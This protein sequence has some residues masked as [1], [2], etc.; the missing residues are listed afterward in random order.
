MVAMAE[1]ALQ[2]EGV[3][4]AAVQGIADACRAARPVTAAALVM[5]AR[6][7]GQVC[8]GGD[9]EEFARDDVV[10]ALLQVTRDCERSARWPPDDAAR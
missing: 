8:R 6:C 9:P 3:G 5:I 2:G 10:D 4:G 7:V 1:A